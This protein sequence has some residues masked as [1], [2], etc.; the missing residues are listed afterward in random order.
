MKSAESI[1]TFY[2]TNQARSAFYPR[3]YQSAERSADNSSGHTSRTGK[4]IAS[5]VES[6]DTTDLQPG[7]LTARLRVAKAQQEEALISF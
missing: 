6:A 3:K 7:A 5:A 4:M 2:N 1:S